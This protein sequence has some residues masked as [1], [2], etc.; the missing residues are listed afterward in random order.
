MTATIF[1]VGSLVL[2]FVMAR[3]PKIKHDRCSCDGLYDHGCGAGRD[4]DYSG[5]DAG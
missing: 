3:T 1:I 4:T 2:F 5:G